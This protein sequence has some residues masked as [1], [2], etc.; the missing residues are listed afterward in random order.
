MNRVRT[1]LVV[2][3]SLSAALL[4]VSSL[5]HIGGGAARFA[6][7]VENA[8]EDPDMPTGL[9][10]PALN[11]KDFMLRPAEY[12]A[13]R[14]GIHKGQPVDLKLRQEAITMLE[15]QESTVAAARNAFGVNA[16]TSS[17]VWTELGPNPIPNGQVLTG[18][19]LAVS[20]RTIAIAVH[21]TNPNIVYVG[22]AQGG[23]YRSTDG[24]TTWT[25]L[26]DN[27][28]SLAI[29]AIAIAPSQPDTV[30]VGTVDPNFSLDSFF[31]VGVYRIT[32]AT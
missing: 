11:R 8:G 23:L 30:Y 27:A 4:L 28:Q 12:M 25:P 22:A 13:M 5:T 16:P 20:G 32:D 1:A 19:P 7:R 6:I 29:G 2:I 10:L 14:R 3:L 26:M 21:P 24:G 18:S 31:G 9:G 17:T 15:A